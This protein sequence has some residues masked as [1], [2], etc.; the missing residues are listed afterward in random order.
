MEASPS[1]LV[2]TAKASPSAVKDVA[3]QL[4]AMPAVQAVSQH[5]SIVATV[6]GIV[7]S[8]DQVMTLLVL[9]SV[10]LALVILY[11]LTNINIAERVRELSTIR[12]LGF[13]DKEVT[14][15][16]TGK[17]CFCLLLVF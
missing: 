10:L 6:T 13:Y 16:F 9:L 1:Y 14:Y 3:S 2:T 5:S 4:L 17:P 11:H 7:A 15:T 8:L 12:V